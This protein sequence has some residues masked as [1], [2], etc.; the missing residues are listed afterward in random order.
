[1]NISKL[2]LFK[3]MLFL[4]G[5]SCCPGVGWGRVAVCTFLYLWF[6]FSPVLS[7]TAFSEQIALYIWDKGGGPALT[8]VPEFCTDDAGPH[9]ATTFHSVL[10]LCVSKEKRPSPAEHRRMHILCG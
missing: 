3:L 1:M 6:L 2:A 5:V 4:E 9:C 10:P 7:N 8:A